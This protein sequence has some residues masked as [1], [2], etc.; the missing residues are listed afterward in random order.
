MKTKKNERIF[1]YHGRTFSVTVKPDGIGGLAVAFINEYIPTRKIFK[2]K[3][4]DSINFWIDDF[5]TIEDG[6]KAMLQK[7]LNKEQERENYK[8]KWSEFENNT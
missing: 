1:E 5:D 8:N 4:H 6:A 3:Y 7:V 2:W